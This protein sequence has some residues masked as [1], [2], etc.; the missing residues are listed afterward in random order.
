MK[1]I[2]KTFIITV[3]TLLIQLVFFLFSSSFTLA[4]ANFLVKPTLDASQ[5][6]VE[7][8]DRKS[9]VFRCLS[10]RSFNQG[11]D[12]FSWMGKT[13]T[14]D[15]FLTFVRTEESIRGSI[16]T[17]K[18]TFKIQGTLNNPSIILNQ[19]LAK[20]CGGC[21][22]NDEIIK[23]PRSAAQRN[24]TWRKSDADQIDLMVVY[25][26]VVKNEIGSSA[27]TLAE[28]RAAVIDTNLCFRNSGVN[29]QLRLVHCEE[30]SYVP[31]GNLDL[32]LER[33]TEKSDGFLDE[34]HT[35]RD[36]YGADIVTLLS[37]DS[38]S[39]GLANTLSFPTIKFE[40]KAFN[41]CVWDQI[42]APG[43]TLAHEVGHNMGCLHN[44][45][46]ADLTK[47]TST[48]DFGEFAYGKRWL[49][50]SD[51][52]KTVMSYNNDTSSYQH[53]IPYFSNPQISYLGTSTGNQ[54]SEN[55]AKALNLSIPYVAN[56]RSS[57]IQGILPSLFEIDV[58]EGRHS[59]FSVRL[60]VM[61]NSPVTLSLS[62]SDT[63]DF[64][65]ASP[66]AII[67]DENN[68]NLPHPISVYAPD[69]GSISSLGDTIQVAANGMDS[70]NISLKEKESENVG[71]YISGIVVNSLGVGVD[72]VVL[73]SENN[74]TLM[75]TDENGTFGSILTS[76]FTGVIQLQKKGYE[77]EPNS[78]TLSDISTNSLAHSI[79]ATRSTIVYVDK[80]A[81]G[82][83]D[84]T[85]WEN[86]FTSLSEALQVTD[87]FT[88]V[89]VAEGT[90]YSGDVR[91]SSFILPPGIELLGGFSG[92]ETSSS[93]R[94][95]SLNQTILSGAVGSIEGNEYKSYHVLVA[96][97]NSVLDGFIIEDG[98]AS[99]NFTDERGVGGGLWAEGSTFVVRNCQF[100]NNFV[101]QGGGAVWLKNANA[102]FIN[103]EFS[104]NNTGETGSGGA[105]WLIE[106][107]ATVKSCSF[108]ENYS[109]FWGG[110]IR[111]D[112]S[113][114][115]I[116]D[117]LFSKNSSFSSNGGGGVYQYGGVLKVTNSSF[118][119]NHSTH[120]GGGIL[121]ADSNAT[122]SDSNFT[123]NLNSDYNGGGALMIENS[124]CVVTKC[125]FTN[126]ETQ[127]NSF[128]GAIKIASSSPTISN[129][130]FTGNKN[131]VNS[132]GAIYIDEYSAPILSQNNFINNSSSSWG[133]AIY[134]QSPI[135]SV[136][137]G[138]FMGNWS[139]L[140]GGI[141]TY[142]TTDISLNGVK[143]LGN[144]ANASSGGNGG[145]FYMGTEA[146]SSK[147]VNCIFA[148]N[149]SNNRH[150]VI[151]IKGAS[152]FVNSTFYGNQASSG[153]GI[154]LL[155]TG[156]S[157]ILQNCILWDNS[158]PNGYEIWVNSGDASAEYSLLESSKSP[159][160]NLELNNLTS[161]PGFVDPVGPDLIVGTLDDD[162]R[163]LSTSS[164]INMGSDSF[165]NYNEND[166]VGI[167]RDSSPDLGA[168]EY[169]QNSNP[170]YQ[171]ATNFN[172]QEGS[173]IIA[174][175]NGTDAD[176]HSLTYSIIGGSDESMILVDA[177]TGVLRFDEIPDYE[178]PHDSNKDNQYF[179]TINISDGYASIQVNLIVTVLDIDDSASS[180]EEAM[181]LFN[182][183]VLGEGWRQASWFGTYYSDLYPWVYHSELLWVYIVQ[184]QNG[185]MWFW[186]ESQGWLWTTP[187][188]FPFYYQN[189]SG[190][191]AYL[192]SGNFLGKYYLFDVSTGAGWYDIE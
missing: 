97:D 167:V 139:Y 131:T 83:N 151:A 108:S 192:G 93:Q 135:F 41:V 65:L 183:Y 152:N 128:G 94:D 157:I 169:F 32:D 26:T 177:N 137:G 17:P 148:G 187:S 27:S 182:G 166:I 80:Q 19:F 123:E 74:Q 18:K 64:L 146:S 134:T 89:W 159:G 112:S 34:I 162:L 25:P 42:T 99:E 8:L 36:S 165:L 84:G 68:W 171:G 75:V 23:D 180:P 116:E 154:S 6:V 70:V 29:I 129:C 122:I 87:S 133:G 106:S 113:N 66:S 120:E 149:K 43:Y 140:G 58:P 3:K 67:L 172:I 168:Y 48:Y 79:L 105:I 12:E 40:D 52:Y 155:F 136:T 191:W 11:N 118:T 110:A 72:G 111:S 22:F 30:T 181:H 109:G 127:A 77:F 185:N 150:G 31:T 175:I 4:E 96:L 88:E 95:Y 100:R 38:S 104:K 174:E 188:I 5:I 62:I 57:V 16:I 54:G 14:G 142:G 15:N 44:R 170:I 107:N 115:S 10:S 69:N 132:G 60:S 163:L 92:S 47:T 90:Y 33:L 156:D 186:K 184:S 49:V 73:I 53:S 164:A 56:F 35:I 121:L 1:I 24:H 179:L 78:I 160:I 143:A 82:A 45:E 37:T 71:N 147:F 124:S 102:T 55:N 138:F 46:D 125:E 144:E 39:G 59:S 13:A 119:S 173:A 145:F 189:S 141:A 161:D 126:N 21:R 176:G 51:G 153:G 7:N 63:N 85:S 190:I 81:S 86:A 91:S 178:Y 114:L 61:P 20:P 9:L 158:D 130:V 101:Y 28:I 103:C 98:N 117:S 50:G 76:D 2:V